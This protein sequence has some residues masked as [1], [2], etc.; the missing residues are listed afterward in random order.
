MAKIT[1]LPK[2]KQYFLRNNICPEAPDEMID[3]L[4][5]VAAERKLSVF[6]NQISMSVR[7]TRNGP[8]AVIMTTIE[9]ARSIADRTGTYAGSDEIEYGP[10]NEAGFPQWA[11][12][13]VYKMV[14]GERCAFK[15]R[16][17]W[18]EF[19]QDPDKEWSNWR[20]MPYHMLGKVAEMHAL[21]KAWPEDC[22]GIMSDAETVPEVEDEP[23]T[24][25]PVVQERPS[26][27]ATWLKASHA[28]RE[29]GKTPLD[30][31]GHIGKDTI[32]NVTDQDMQSLQVWFSKLREE[33]KNVGRT[34]GT[35]PDNQNAG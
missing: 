35:G 1:D 27:E 22:S 12:C 16:V 32:G 3:Y 33:S 28:F 24:E 4:L 18:A 10:E 20:K 21:K 29:F 26:I 13:T 11:S 34:E 6:S 5:T 14:H 7:K 23:E 31:L 19:A 9:G 15:A 30:M 25:A 8:R 2:E 17:R